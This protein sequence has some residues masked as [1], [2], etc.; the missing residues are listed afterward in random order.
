MKQN[1]HHALWYNSLLS[2]H[3]LDM[4]FPYATLFKHI[5]R[6]FLQL[7]GNSPPFSILSKLE[8]ML[9]FLWKQESEFIFVTFPLPSPTWLLKRLIFHESF[10]C[11]TLPVWCYRK[12]PQTLMI[13]GGKVS[14]LVHCEFKSLKSNRPFFHIYSL[15]ISYRDITSLIYIY[16]YLLEI[17]LP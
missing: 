15:V 7:Q 11:V 5:E 8:Y 16:S 3:Q 10:I 4:K 6:I 13:E 17:R 1:M 9:I 12:Q 2:L 14:G